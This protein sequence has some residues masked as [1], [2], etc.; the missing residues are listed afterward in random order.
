[1]PRIIF[2][3]VA[4][5]ITSWEEFNH[6]LI[7]LVDEILNIQEIPNFKLTCLQIWMAYLKQTEA[8]FFDKKMNVAPKLFAYH[9]KM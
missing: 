2:F 7:G 1:M 4:R 6:I 3:F 5:R 8:A 9:R